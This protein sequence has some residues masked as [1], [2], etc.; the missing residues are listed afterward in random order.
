MRQREE[1][2]WTWRDNLSLPIERDSFSLPVER[3]E[4]ASSKLDPEF[5]T[6][7]EF[8]NEKSNPNVLL[9]FRIQRAFSNSEAKFRCVVTQ[10]TLFEAKLRAQRSRSFKLAGLVSDP[11]FEAAPSP[12]DQ[13]SSKGGCSGNRV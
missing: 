4:T 6:C 3:E 5:E 8:E 11:S 7:A 1:R 12:L 9:K 2:N 13:D 10:T